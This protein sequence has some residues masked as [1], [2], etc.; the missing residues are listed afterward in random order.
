MSYVLLFNRNIRSHFVLVIRNLFDIS[1][2]IGLVISYR[3]VYTV[4]QLKKTFESNRNSI[5]NFFFHFV[6]YLPNCN[7]NNHFVSSFLIYFFTSF[8]LIHFLHCRSFLRIGT[9]L[10]D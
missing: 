7:Y 4:L 6:R 3:K 5:T 8:Y 9:N 1:L 10:D 2:C